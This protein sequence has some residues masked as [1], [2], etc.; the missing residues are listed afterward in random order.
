MQHGMWHLSSL[1]KDEP[2]PLVLEVQSL[3]YWPAG[4]SLLHLFLW[5]NKTFCSASLTML[6]PLT[7]WITTNCAKFLKRWEY[8]VTSPDSWEFCMWA[9]KQQ[10]TGHGIIDWFKIG[11]FKVKKSEQS[12]AAEACWAHNPEVDGS[13][14]SSAKD[15]VKS[16]VRMASEKVYFIGFSGGSVSKESA[17][18]VWD[19]GSIPGSGRP[20]G[21][22]NLLPTPVVLLGESHWQRNLVG[23]SSWSRKELGATDTFTLK[24][25]SICERIWSDYF[26]MFGLWIWCLFLTFSSLVF[27]YDEV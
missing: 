1:T 2:A 3:N 9:K 4:N 7:V 24:F 27:F 22:G 21:E 5:P 23:Y 14:P 12:G 26:G 10:W 15:F 17:C 8:Q 18:V 19:S 16:W 13:K 6:K 20:L 25:G 11:E